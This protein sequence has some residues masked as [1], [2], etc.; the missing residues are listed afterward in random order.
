[1]E[2]KYRGQKQRWLLFHFLGDDKEININ[3]KHPEFKNWLWLDPEILP[4]KAIFFKKDVYQKIN[5][6]FIPI[7]NNFNST[8]V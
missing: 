8:E 3:T 7:L 1:M 6:I 2:S 4:E 5:K